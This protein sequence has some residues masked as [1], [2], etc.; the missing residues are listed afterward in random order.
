[1]GACTV[2]L[3]GRAARS[4]Q[5]FPQDLAGRRITTIEGLSA[6]GDHPIQ[7]SGR[8]G[9]VRSED[10]HSSG[11]ETAPCFSAVKERS[12]CSSGAR[13]ASLPPL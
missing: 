9:R 3:E 4:C 13:A 7:F 6:Q 1:M 8:D 5:L 12:V 2:H 10:V 11:A